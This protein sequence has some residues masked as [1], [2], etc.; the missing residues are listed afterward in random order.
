[1]KFI[2]HMLNVLVISGCSVNNHLVT[3]SYLNAEVLIVN[4]LLTHEE[5]LQD[6][7]LYSKPICLNSDTNINLKKMIG[8]I[9]NV[10]DKKIVQSLIYNCDK[11]NLIGI[12]IKV[13]NKQNLGQLFMSRPAI[14]SNGDKAF[15]IY[16][17]L[18][19]E[20]FCVFKRDKDEWILITH[21]L[22]SIS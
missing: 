13:N 18:A 15:L 22:Y 19:R 20:Y 12:N 5:Y 1:M 9:S 2:V 17:Y 21:E 8:N 14:Y 16:S 6:A 10:D 7:I 11:W 4:S 3:D